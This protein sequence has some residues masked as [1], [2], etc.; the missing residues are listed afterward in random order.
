MAAG[1]SSCGD[2]LKE[3]SQELT[4]ATSCKD[5]SELLIGGG[6]MNYTNL[7][8]SLTSDD[9]YYLPWIHV[10]DDDVRELLLGSYVDPDGS[11][12]KLAGFHR[13]EKNPYHQNDI[14]YTDMN[15]Y[16]FY[17]HIAI[18]NVI[19]HKAADFTD[20]PIEEQLQVKGESYF[21]RAAYYFLLVNVYAKPYEKSTASSTPGVPLKISPQIEDRDYSR[22]SVEEIYRQIVSD[23]EESV[24]CFGEL[25]AKSIHRAGGAAALTLLSRVYC[26]MGEWDKVPE[27]CDRVLAMGEYSLLDLNSFDFTDSRKH[28][29][30]QNSPEIIFTMGG[31]AWGQISQ[32]LKYPVRPVSTF[33]VS[34]ELKYRVLSENDLRQK[35]FFTM[36][37]FYYEGDPTYIRPSKYKAKDSQGKPV[38]SI[39]LIRLPEVYL[40]MA[41]AHA[42]NGDEGKAIA[43]LQELR[44]M[45][46]AP[47]DLGTIGLSGEEL[48]NYIRD[49][50]RRELCFEGHRWFD[51]KRYAV[52]PVYPY[53][54]VLR[55][56]YYVPGTGLDFGSVG[57]YYE[58]GRYSDDAGGYV[59][60]MPDGEI[61]MNNGALVNNERPERKLIEL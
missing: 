45:R 9:G 13:W 37:T 34:D 47:A 2:F 25:P 23:L 46:F 57:G 53:E 6:Y 39:F 4:Y 32:D 14:P 5:L 35:A 22:N 17:E 24:K 20:D 18:L 16:R 44:A 33:T 1:L 10:M 56:D 30:D 51:L 40:N 48:V 43:A 15:W 41:E 60:T 11:R 42:M 28:F 61:E 7:T 54:K 58:L 27:L 21:L 12:E 55:H 29:I 49:E 3:H 26:Y 19:L 8:G 59:M 50:R 31:Y 36:A 52:S 38:S